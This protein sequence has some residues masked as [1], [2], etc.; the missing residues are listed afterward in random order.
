[1]ISRGFTIL[2]RVIFFSF[3]NLTVLLAS[4]AGQRLAIVNPEKNMMADRI[5]EI[6]SKSL[7]AASLGVDRSLG[8]TAFASVQAANPFNLSR[9]EARRAGA[10]IGC[11]AFILIKAE[12]L[13]RTSSRKAYFESYAA[14]YVISSRTGH[15]II[16]RLAASEA[17]TSVDA[18]EDLMRATEKL[19]IEI[20][21][22]LKAG[23][24]NDS[25]QPNSVYPEPPAENSPEAKNFRAPVPYLRIKPEY[26]SLAFLYD[27]RGTIEIAVD[28]DEK[29]ALTRT[30]ITRWAG[31]GLDDSVIDA[32]RK[33]NW[34]PAERN[35]KPLP[36]HFLL[37]YNFKKIEK[38]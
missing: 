31:F 8:N 26:T 10:A 30:E 5:G 36:M 21:R 23:L 13:R 9:D 37:R 16:W 24:A 28:L 11:D 2:S 7:P 29:G 35:G 18:E 32:V 3:L 6:F 34:R 27:I 15:L 19:A 4:T 33:M 17:D 1:M 14:F 22:D 25:S 20:S 12:T 38:D